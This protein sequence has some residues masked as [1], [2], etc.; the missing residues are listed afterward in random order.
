LY[1]CLYRGRYQ[2]TALHAI[3]LIFSAVIVDKILRHS[4]REINILALKRINTRIYIID[5]LEEIIATLL[6]ILLFISS[7]SSSLSYSSIAIVSIYLPY[8]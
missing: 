7:S 6:L 8:L 5:E 2:F 4:K 1:S 3:I